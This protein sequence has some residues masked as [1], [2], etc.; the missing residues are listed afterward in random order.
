M[1]VEQAG[2]SPVSPV[3]ALEATADSLAAVLEAGVVE[4][5]TTLFKWK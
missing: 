3:I 4:T 2:K 5:A 1:A